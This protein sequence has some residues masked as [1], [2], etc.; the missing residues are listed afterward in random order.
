MMPSS[1]RATLLRRL[2]RRGERGYVAV[3]TGLVLTVLLCFCAFA[4]DVGNWYFTGQRMQRAADAGALAGVT[5]LPSDFSSANTKARELAKKNNFDGSVTGTTVTSALDGRPTRLRVTVTQTVKNQ[6]G[7][8]MGVPTTQV[9]RTAVADYA[10]PVPMGSPCNEYGDD[11]DQNGNRSSNCSDA[12]AF[13][14][15][16]GSPNATKVS[17][18]A[19]Q[20]NVCDSSQDGCASG[21]NTDYDP[22]G[23]VYL[24]TLTAPVTNLRIQAF[25]PA[26]IA[27]GD[28]CGNG[29]ANLDDADS[30][31]T[32]APTGVT[33][34]STRYAGGAGA[35]CTGDNV[36]NGGNGLVKTQFNVFQA[37][38]TS[39]DWAPLTWP[40]TCTKTFQPY[41]G[42][43]ALVLDKTR[44]SGSLPAN[45][46]YNYNGVA[47]NFRRWVD[48]CTY[49]GTVPAGTYAIQVKTNGLGAD[50]EG[51]HNRF[52]LRAFGSGA[53][54]K[55]NISV[56]GF[57]KMGM[58]GNTPSGTSKFFL[59]RVPTGARGQLF[60]VRLFD[61]G[62]GATSGSWIQVLPRP[63]TGPL[64]PSPV[65][66]VRARARA[67]EP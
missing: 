24:V 43:L 33:N 37:T 53:N 55:D 54:D 6:F 36:I 20:N 62:D 64:P 66:W 25:D 1:L 14:A 48:L 44:T 45:Q 30:L 19:Y 35:Y 16:I 46:R 29:S 40:Q 23:Y 3:M 4:V 61:I 7:W 15:N 12:G 31:G 18:D 11:P 50:G 27:V 39:N 58:Y 17:G 10:G 67:P 56:A 51:G 9:S 38:P 26:M 22:N 59:A 60:K 21:T 65:V 57:N 52:G 28:T 63:R 49:S 42:D 8:L 2:S 5:Y 13:W 34:A 47:D 41:N 32:N